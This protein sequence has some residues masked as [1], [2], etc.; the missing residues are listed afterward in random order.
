MCRIAEVLLTLQQAGNV[1]YTGWMLQVPCSTDAQLVSVLQAKAKEMEKELTQWKQT[2]KSKRE[3]YYELNYYTTHQLLTLRRELGRL[4]ADHSATVSPDVLFLLQSVSTHVTPSIISEA[5]CGV[6]TGVIAIQPVPLNE[7]YPV[8]DTSEVECDDL[9][10]LP[11]SVTSDISTLPAVVVNESEIIEHVVARSDHTEE[12]LREMIAD[13]CSRLECSR[14]FVLRCLRECSRLIRDRYDLEE[15]CGKR[16]GDDDDDDI[17]DEEAD[18]TRLS[19]I[20]CDDS[21]ESD[22]EERVI[23]E[24]GA[25][26]R[27]LSHSSMSK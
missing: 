5:V 7:E 19:D 11:T 23:S 1:N 17:D 26:N 16:L 20:Y 2:M 9:T 25:T 12:D 24:P 8:T 6:T 15:E 22:L 14:K 4:Q 13:V 27:E 3:G 10:E 21:G 18:D